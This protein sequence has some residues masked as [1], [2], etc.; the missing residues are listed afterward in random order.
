GSRRRGA[1]RWGWACACSCGGEALSSSSCQKA[2]TRAGHPP[3]GRR[4]P[5]AAA[6]ILSRRGSSRHGDMSRSALHS[7]AP[8]RTALLRSAPRSPA[9]TR[10]VTVPAGSAAVLLPPQR[11]LHPRVELQLHQGVREVGF[12]GGHLDE[13][14]PG[15]LL[16]RAALGDEGQHV[17]LAP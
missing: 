5:S 1:L 16:V 8:H 14:L 6:V 17:L 13:Q 7:T 10:A 4:T 12:H 15:D 11:R 9:L 2:G 3:A